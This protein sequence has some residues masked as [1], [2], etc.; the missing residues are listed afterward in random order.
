MKFTILPFL[1]ILLTAVNSITLSNPT[2]TTTSTIQQAKAYCGFQDVDDPWSFPFQFC[3]LTAFTQEACENTPYY[4]P[5]GKRS[6]CVWWKPEKLQQIKYSAFCGHPKDGEPWDYPVMYCNEANIAMLSPKNREECEATEVKPTLAEHKCIWNE[7]K[8]CIAENPENND[9]CQV[10]IGESNCMK[11]SFFAVHNKCVWHIPP[12]SAEIQAQSI[13]N[14]TG[15][16]VSVSPSKNP[17]SMPSTVPSK[18]PSRSNTQKPTISTD[19]ATFKPPLKPTPFPTF[20]IIRAPIPQVTRQPTH[21]NPSTLPTRS[22]TYSPTKFSTSSPTFYPTISTPKP[23]TKH[24]TPDPSRSP[25]ITR[26]SFPSKWKSATPT[27]T[28]SMEVSMSPSR[29]TTKPTLFRQLPVVFPT[30]APIPMSIPATAYSM[31]PSQ[32]RLPLPDAGKE[33]ASGSVTGAII[34]GAGLASV[35]VACIGCACCCCYVRRRRQVNIAFAGA[36]A[37]NVARNMF[38]EEV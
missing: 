13:T 19:F 14:I 25:T 11:G 4:G 8:G 30:R 20:V 32:S 5:S 17:S 31:A 22:P 35:A 24:P 37:K 33:K 15:P 36:D 1:S 6:S 9:N 3:S 16:S 26:S 27:S 12:S 10:Y 34:V 29:Y 7:N 23:I 28:P 21:L 38:V 18:S 2:S